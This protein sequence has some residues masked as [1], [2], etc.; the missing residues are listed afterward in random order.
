MDREIP[1]AID[2]IGGRS[3][4]FLVKK[5]DKDSAK[6]LYEEVIESP[7]SGSF[8]KQYSML[9]IYLLS[10]A[11]SLENK[12]KIKIL[13]QLSAPDSPFHVLAL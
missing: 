7:G 3:I 1:M 11:E 9:M 13:D 4:G 8:F 5:G 6:R 2:I 12:N 10:P